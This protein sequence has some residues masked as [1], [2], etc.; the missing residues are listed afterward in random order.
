V[1]TFRSCRTDGYWARAAAA[2][3]AVAVLTAAP[4]AAQDKQ[5]FTAVRFGASAPAAPAASAAA[6]DPAAQAPASPDDAFLSFFRGTELGG[7]ADAY[8]AYYSTKQPALFHAFDAAHN[9]FTLSMAEIWLNKAPAA[10]SRVGFKVKLN[11]GPAATAINFA[12]P[13][14]DL[15]NVEEGYASYLAPV[16]KGLQ[17]DVGKFVTPAGAEVIEAK[18]DWNYSRSLL[19]QNAIPFYHV[20]VRAT[21][22]ATDKVTLMGGV[23]NGWNNAVE[24]NT[25]KTVLG[26]ITLKPTAAFSVIEN[27]IGGPEQPGNN[28]DW[29]NLSDTVVSYT[30]SPMVSLL[31]NYDYA[32]EAIAGTSVHW[33]GVAGYAK[34][35][36]N[37]HV[38][39]IPRAEYFD[40]EAGFSGVVQKIKEFT[41]T[42]E[43]KAADNFLWRVEYRGDFSDAAPFTSASGLP[44]KSQHAIVFGILYNFST[45][46]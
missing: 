39:F 5:P 38:A 45:K 17:V 44:K 14:R 43:L 6:A 18:D 9:Q 16:G 40:D 34:L 20:G 24:N 25:G 26:S 32:R 22:T 46:A 10:D 12:E 21:Y 3:L 37:K 28:S 2:G 35:Q 19:F 1:I 13:N 15:V 11:F 4:A 30:A 42:T 36:A 41:F 33:Q 31:F 8:Y 29:R 23:V 27:Y 7:L